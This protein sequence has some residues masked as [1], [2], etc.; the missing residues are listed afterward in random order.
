MR[1]CAISGKKAIWIELPKIGEKLDLID[2]NFDFFKN[3][4]NEQKPET[5]Y[6]VENIASFS[7]TSGMTQGFKPC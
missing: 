5:E 1:H 2:N 6:D 7:I 3:Y 4:I